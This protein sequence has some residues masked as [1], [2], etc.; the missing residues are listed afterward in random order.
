MAQLGSDGMPAVVH[1]GSNAFRAALLRS[2][3]HSP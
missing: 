1:A 2:G 3:P